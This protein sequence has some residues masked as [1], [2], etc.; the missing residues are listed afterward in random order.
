MVKQFIQIFLLTNVFCSLVIGTEEEMPVGCKQ[1]R[2][3][4][5]TNSQ[6][7]Q[8]EYYEDYLKTIENAKLETKALEP[9]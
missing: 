6:P 5:Q 4:A 1:C 9:I 3:R 8:Y 7:N 2:L